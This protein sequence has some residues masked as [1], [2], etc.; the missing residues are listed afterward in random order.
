MLKIYDI[1]TLTV[2]FVLD[3]EIVV[4]L[5]SSESCLCEWAVVNMRRK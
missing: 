2:S 5:C 3:S 1:D 4:S